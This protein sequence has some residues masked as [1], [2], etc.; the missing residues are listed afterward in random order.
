MELDP[1]IYIVM[2]SVLSL[3]LGVIEGSTLD[4]DIELEP[5][6][7]MMAEEEPK[8]EDT[9]LSPDELTYLWR[10]DGGAL[11]KMAMCNIAQDD[12]HWS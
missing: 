11:Q 12:A 1:G 9:C 10:T 6:Q 2:H 5:L 3:K 7:R 8:K 4:V